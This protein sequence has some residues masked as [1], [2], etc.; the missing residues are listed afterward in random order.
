GDILPGES[1]ADTEFAVKDTLKYLL[2]QEI[3]PVILGGSQDLTYTQ[4]RAYDGGENM[5]NLVNIDSRFDI[6][7]S[8]NEITNLSYVGRMIVDK[9]YN[10]FNY[11]NLGYQT[12]L[13]PPE[14]IELIERLYFEA[15]RL[16]DLRADMKL[17]E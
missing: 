5:V 13:N 7:N 6:G 2:E 4:Y 17:A 3:I 1:V 8:E 10:L 16:G 12:Y 11:A 14:E 15:Y 9:P